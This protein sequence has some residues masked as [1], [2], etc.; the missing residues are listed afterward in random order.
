MAHSFKTAIGGVNSATNN[1][2]LVLRDLLAQQVVLSEEYLLVKSTQLPESYRIKEHEHSRA[3]RMV[4]AGKILTEVVAPIEHPVQEF[5][6]LAENI[7]GDAMQLASLRG[8]QRAPD[9]GP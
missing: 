1:G 6:V 9:K 5:T 8:F 2:E 7:R 4:Q 3:V